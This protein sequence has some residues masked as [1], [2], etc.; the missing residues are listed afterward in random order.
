MPK[1]IPDRF[2]LEF[3]ARAAAFYNGGM[4]WKAAC[5]ELGVPD[6]SAYRVAAR[7][8]AAARRGEIPAIAGHPVDTRNYRRPA[9]KEPAKPPRIS[10][11]KLRQFQGLVA[12][13]SSPEQALAGVDIKVSLLE[14]V[15]ACLE[16]AIAAGLVTPVKWVETKVEV[17]SR[18]Y[19]P[20]PAGHPIAWGAIIDGTILR[21]EPY[22]E[23]LAV[24]F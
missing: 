21:G 13:G 17:A 8:Y 14:H 7:A 15:E 5:R 2:S 3:L 1:G 4:T 18:A 9:A 22:P 11:R 20:L 24:A 6:G 23:H 12:A 16:Q 19:D 10:L